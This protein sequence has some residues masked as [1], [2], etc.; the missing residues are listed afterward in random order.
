[1][2]AI[3]LWLTAQ[4]VGAI[5]IAVSYGAMLLSNDKMH[6]KGTAAGA[7]ID[8]VHWLLLAAYTGAVLAF[9][10]A[11]RMLVSL[12]NDYRKII[13]SVVFSVLFVFVSLLTWENIYSFLPMSGTVIATF[14][15]FHSSRIALRWWLIVCNIPWIIYSVHVDSFPGVFAG[16]IAVALLGI[17]ILKIKRLDTHEPIPGR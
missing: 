1:M 11:I 2:S 7:L 12:N 15:Y 6:V 13:T 14:A 16:V 5:A 17:A 4:V 9:L 8:A 10:I 3:D